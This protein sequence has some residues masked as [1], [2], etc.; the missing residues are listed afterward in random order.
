MAAGGCEGPD[1]VNVKVR[2]SPLRH[3]NVLRADPDM[4]VDFGLLAGG[5]VSGP[6]GDVLVQAGPHEPR[7]NKAAGCPAAWVGDAV[8]VVK[9]LAAM[10]LRPQWSPHAGRVVA[11]QL[12]ATYVHKNNVE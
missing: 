4:S 2:K 11:C 9:H 8:D 12:L 3:R 5:A 7:R 6:G 1:Q 10:F